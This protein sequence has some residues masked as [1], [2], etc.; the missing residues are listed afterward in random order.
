M[1]KAR[2]FGFGA[3]LVLG[4]IAAWIHTFEKDYVYKALFY[5]FADIDDN[6][7]FAQREIEAPAVPQPWP[8]AENYNELQMPQELAQLH[9][10]LESVAFLVI[11]DDSILYEQ[12]WDG[13]SDESLSNSFSMAKS[14][15]SMLVGAAIKEGKIKSVE[16]P[17]GDFLP[18]FREGDKA[19]IKI[20]HLLWMS[21]GL[22]WDESYS[23][24]F[25]MTTEA[26]Y[27]TDL[28]RLIGRLEAV[29]EPGK[30]F[31]YKSGDTQ[32]LGFV[33]EAAT[34]ESLSAYAEEKLWKPLGAVHDAEWS[35]DRPDGIEKAYCCFFSNA[36][37]FARL[38][39]LYLQHGIWNG[40]T[41]VPP[42]YVEVSLTPSG[43]VKESD[44]EE[45][46]FYGY[47]WW[48]LPDYRG[49]NVFYARGILGQYVIVVPEEDLIIV[50]LGKQRGE[51]V[52]EHPGEVLAMLDA[53]TEMIE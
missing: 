11:K 36:R 4:L 49:Q 33:V 47:Q 25:S 18:D 12:Y 29:E 50:R 22:N 6:E 15:V 24:P 46:D 30:E 23:S 35:V 37:D 19:K 38:G 10:E 51:R 41:I 1:R 3:L 40:D 32:V 45:V 31:S 14:V 2:R 34:G 53:V 21:S 42:A 16:Q 7:I 26:Y 39:K 28:K 5:N 27:G 20:K 9:E 43:L 17:V 52:G 13:Y 44:G 48:L 8:L